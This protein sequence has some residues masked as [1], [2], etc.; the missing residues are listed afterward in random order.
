MTAGP[1]PARAEQLRSLQREEGTQRLALQAV[2]EEQREAE[3]AVRLLRAGRGAASPT[4][5]PSRRST[6]TSDA[7]QWDALNC[8]GK[9]TH[10]TRS[11]RLI[12]FRSPFFMTNQA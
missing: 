3:A 2:R 8:G 6:T 5:L 9:H 11:F 1:L 4:E 7:S 10:R 12:N